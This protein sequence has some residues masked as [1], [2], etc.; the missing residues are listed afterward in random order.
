MLQI[1]VKRFIRSIKCLNNLTTYVCIYYTL[2]SM[3]LMN[4]GK[5][6][7][8]IKS[9]ATKKLEKQLAKAL[10]ADKKAHDAEL[11]RKRE[12][13]QKLTQEAVDEV[14]QDYDWKTKDIKYWAGMRLNHDGSAEFTHYRF[15]I[16]EGS[17]TIPKDDLLGLQKYLN[18]IL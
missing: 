2:L 13:A 16:S 9:E 12:E 3:K 11:L 1:K 7:V 10:A 17:M 15:D 5:V 6:I 14:K 4:L 8:M 18:E